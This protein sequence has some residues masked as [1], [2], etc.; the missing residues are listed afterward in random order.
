VVEV[1]HVRPAF[2][3][4][5]RPEPSPRRASLSEVGM[6]IV[7]SR[8]L[9]AVWRVVP[10]HTP[11]VSRACPRCGVATSF[12]SSDKFRVNASGR[13]L[14]V[15]LIYRC[16]RCQTAWNRTVASRVAPEDL[17]PRLEAYHRNDLDTAWACAFDAA[18]GGGAGPRPDLAVA[19]RL[20]RHGEAV[21]AIRLELPYP[22][23]VRLHRLLAGELGVS[24]TALAARRPD[25]PRWAADGQVIA[26]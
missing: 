11:R 10:L 7:V 3:T 9:A 15:W 6:V 24:R 26:L 5:V 22:I 17:G 18:L 21:G 4:Y 19:Y 2:A 14:D 25:L 1:G 8:S 16:P 13:R 12:S 23:R 20:E